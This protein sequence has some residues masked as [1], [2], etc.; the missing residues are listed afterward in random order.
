MNLLDNIVWHA[1]SGPQ[2]RFSSGTA[3]ARRYATGFSPMVAFADCQQPDFEAL[4]PWCESGENFYC[5]DWTGPPPPGWCVDVETTMHRMVWDG[6]LPEEPAPP[7]TSRPLQPKDADAALALALL[8]K[9]GPFG[10]RTIELGEYL[11]CFDAAGALIAMAGERMHAPGL[12]EV[13]GVCTHPGHQG[14][15]LA[16]KLMLQLL[17]RQ[18]QRGEQPFL[19]VMAS[20]TG[21]LGLYE[22][23]GF[24]TYKVCPVR[25]VTRR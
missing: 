7:F 10:P 16:R 17:R 18:M 2:Q 11:G 12:R 20:N 8:T 15:G 4:A 21:A 19:H 24:R 3:T 6:G 22:R 23:M 13:S 5:A 14:K 9:P 25:V 1:L